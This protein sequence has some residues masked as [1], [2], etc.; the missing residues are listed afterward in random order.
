MPAL[1]NDPHNDGRLVEIVYV[2]RVDLD[3][4]APYGSPYQWDR[5]RQEWRT[6]IRVETAYTTA[7]TLRG[8]SVCQWYRRDL[9]GPYDFC[10]PRFGWRSMDGGTPAPGYLVAALNAALAGEIARRRP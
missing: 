4:D 2:D 10:P 9:R 7:I 6:R 8:R 3:Q 1:D 5:D